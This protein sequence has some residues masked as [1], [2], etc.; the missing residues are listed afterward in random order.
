MFL[1]GCSYKYE[2]PKNFHYHEVNTPKFK[3]ASWQSIKNKESP[4]KIYIEGDGSAFDF[5][6]RVT[7]NPTPRGHM[8]RDIAFKDGA[9]NVIYL[10]RPCQYVK[11]KECNSSYWSNARFS[12]EV[13]ESVSYAIKSIVGSAD[14]VLIGYSGG[15]QVAGLVAVLNHDIKVVKIITIAGN[16]DWETW[17]KY[18]NLA[19]LDKSLSLKDFREDFLKIPQIHYVGDEDKVIPYIITKEFVND[20]EKIK[21]LKG[22]SHQNGFDKL[23]Y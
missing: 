21:L 3:I 19:F 16:L 5:H 23:Q 15:A 6:G 2:Y 13:I 10:A 20:D 22:V 8:F 17:V 12:K 1:F 9:D 7:K 11:D 4:Y 18:H 14:V